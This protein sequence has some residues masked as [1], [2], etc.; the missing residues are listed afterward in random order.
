MLLNVAPSPGGL[1]VLVF[2]VEIGVY[3]VTV[4]GLASILYRHTGGRSAGAGGF[5]Q[6]LPIRKAPGLVAW[7][8][9]SG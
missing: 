1:L 2:P 9:C 4:Y 8:L 3:A 5:L 6:P 7:A